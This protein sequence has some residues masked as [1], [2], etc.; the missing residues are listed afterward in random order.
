MD[1]GVGTSGHFHPWLAAPVL[2]A[3]SVGEGGPC[4]FE[5][6]TVLIIS[7]LKNVALQQVWSVCWLRSNPVFV[8]SFIQQVVTVCGQGGWNRQEGNAPCGLGARGRGG[9]S[10]SLSSFVCRGNTCGTYPLRGATDG[11]AAH[12]WRM[13]RAPWLAVS[14]PL[15]TWRAGGEAAP[16][17]QGRTGL[18]CHLIQGGQEVRELVQGHRS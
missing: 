11:D 3:L 10:L 4:R 7:V 17:I 14:S 15:A 16:F 13:A 5:Q 12:A 6:V 1:P 18:S 8:R 2:E 9:A